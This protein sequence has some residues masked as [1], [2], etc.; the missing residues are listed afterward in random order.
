VATRSKVGPIERRIITV[1]DAEGYS[2]RTDDQQRDLQNRMAEILDHAARCARLDWQQAF[3]QG[4]GDGNLTAWPPGTSELVL[5]ADFL[6]ELCG[7]LDRVNRTLSESSKIRLR[8]SVSAGMVQEA[9]QG[10]TG[11]AAIRATLLVDSDQ[12]RAALRKHPGRPLVVIIDDKLFEDV[13]KSGHRGLRPEA[14]QRVAVRGKDG[15]RHVGWITVPGPA[16]QSLSVIGSNSWAGGARPLPADQILPRG[17]NRTKRVSTQVRVALVS[18]AGVIAAVAIAAAATFDNAPGTAAPR[19]ISSRIPASNAALASASSSTSSSSASGRLYREETY[20]HLGTRV[21][22]NPM[23]GAVGGSQSIE[24]GT[25]VLV[26]C[27]APNESGM[28]SINVFYLLETPP[29]TGEYAPA[30]T[31]LNADTK[32]SLDPDVPRCPDGVS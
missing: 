18:A 7:E 28:S 29:W 16:S 4:T 32:G 9:A 27:W 6:R 8:V 21:F 1:S 20:N 15:T 23:G 25:Y 30:N 14:Y 11:Q 22:S 5:I 26:K 19:V 24:F 13:V 17:G 2:K 10:V 31:F 12:L 3:I